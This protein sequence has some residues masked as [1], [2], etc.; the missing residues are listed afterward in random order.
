MMIHILIGGCYRIRSC[1]AKPFLLTNSEYDYTHVSRRCCCYCN[2]YKYYYFC[3]CCP[4][5]ALW[6]L[7]EL[8]QFVSC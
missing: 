2:Y 1:G 4:V 7:L 8:T 5:W 3:R 6:L